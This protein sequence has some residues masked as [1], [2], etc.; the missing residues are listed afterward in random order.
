MKTKRRNYTRKR[1]TKYNV[2]RKTK[3]NVNRKN[4]KRTKQRV[5]QNKTAIL[6]IASQSNLK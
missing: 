4:R 6:L 2:K 3:H 5:K 1:N